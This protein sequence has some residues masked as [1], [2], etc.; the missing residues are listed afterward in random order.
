MR[1]KNYSN[2]MQD[3]PFCLLSVLIAFILLLWWF[4]VHAKANVIQSKCRSPSD[5][6]IRVG[7]TPNFPPFH[8]NNG[9]MDK[10]IFHAVST[11]AGLTKIQWVPFATFDDLL[12]ALTN[13]RID[14]IANNLWKVP[15]LADQFAW[16]MPYY[17][18]G[19]LGFTY[20]AHDPDAP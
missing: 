3:V 16:T 12:L 14:V 2:T 6:I 4:H 17:I 18:K 19:G 20:R 8:M 5:R 11:R 9:G 1:K 10:D 13:Y 7:Y 15:Y